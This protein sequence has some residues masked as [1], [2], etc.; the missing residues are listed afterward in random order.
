MPFAIKAQIDDPH[1]QVFAFP[2]QKTMYGG[3]SISVDDQ[4]FVFASENEG[5]QGLVARGIVVSC[6]P[7]PKLDNVARQ[8]PRVSIV[9]RRTALASRACG[10]RE[11]KPL[12]PGATVGPNPSS[13]SSSI[14]RQ[15]TRSLASPRMRP[16]FLDLSSSP[17][18][19]ATAA[20]LW[21][22]RSRMAASAPDA[23]Q[24]GEWGS[25]PWASIATLPYDER[26]SRRAV[27]EAP[28]E[29]DPVMA[30]AIRNSG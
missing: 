5:G 14:G 10:R 19:N 3:K 6:A 29:V 25:V 23:S 12:R 18:W 2:S 26:C 27:A 20:S 21:G 9:V 22:L 13:M 28:S 8:T 4:V 15:Q 17:P 24:C 7:V 30:E 16:R 1:Q 11:L